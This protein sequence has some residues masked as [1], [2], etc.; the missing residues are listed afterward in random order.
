VRLLA[1]LIP[2]LLTH[3]A[4]SGSSD[5][6][7]DTG[8]VDTDTNDSGGGA[9]DSGNVHDSADTGGAPCNVEVVASVP[10]AGAFDAYYRADVEFVHRHP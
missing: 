9:D 4:C 8:D 10:T 7:S 3:A 2:S 6:K 5:P 1:F